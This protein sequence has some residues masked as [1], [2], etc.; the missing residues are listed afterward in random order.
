MLSKKKSLSL[1]IPIYNEEKV[2]PELIKRLTKFTGKFSKYE[3]EII[4]V[5]HGSVDNSFSLLQKYAKKDKR[6]KILQLS[7]NFGCDGGIAAGLNFARGEAAVIM[8]ADMQEPIDL[9]A[10]FIRK[11]EEGYEIVYG[12][13]KKRTGGLIR[14][15]CSIA[16]YK[17]INLLTANKFPQNASD[18]RLLDRKV[19]QTINEMREQNKY[20]RGLI[21]WTGFKSIGIPFDRQAR[22]AG[23]SK[24]D[25]T[26]V[27]SVAFN[28]IFSF[29]YLPLRFVSYLGLSLTVVS[30]LLILFYFY[31]YLLYGRVVPGV[32]TIILLILILFGLLFFI[33]GIISEYLA[34]IYD[35]VKGRPNFIIKSKT[36]L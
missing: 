25:F 20:L 5:E 34:R 22:F 16:F 17:I 27:L 30:F 26:T 7:K 3:F 15:I 11:W 29:S 32:A 9:I 12:V 33:L 28:G 6:I 21:M 1:I 14:N 13:V 31:L 19:Y 4:L 8:M 36:N 35:E 24:A 10:G 23:K 18:F 2:I